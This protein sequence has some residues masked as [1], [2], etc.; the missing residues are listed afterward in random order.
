MAIC[1]ACE[2]TFSTKH[3]VR[4][5]R[6]TCASV[7]A[8]WELVCNPQ[9]LDQRTVSSKRA[10]L[11]DELNKEKELTE[12]N[13]DAEWEDVPA[14]YEDADVMSPP[15]PI[16]Q[17]PPNI[18][19]P[20][21]T[22]SG[23]VC[24]YPKKNVDFLPN[25]S[26]RIPHM[27]APVPRI[28][29]APKRVAPR[30]PTPEPAAPSFEPTVVVTL[31][32]EFG[33]YRE[34]P[35]F[36]EREIDDFEELD[37]L[38]NAPGLATSLPKESGSRLAKAMGIS[39]DAALAS[40]RFA[41]FLNAT[42]FCLM[43][44]F[45]GNSNL[46]SVQE[47]D[48]LVKN[49][50]LAEDFRVEHLKDFSAQRELARMDE[51]TSSES[52]SSSHSQTEFQRDQGWIN[53]TVKISLPCE[54]HQHASEDAAPVLEVPNVYHRS[55]VGTI[56]A[57][58]QDES[59]E[60]WH[61]TPHRLFWK[62]SPSSSPERIVTKIYN[63]DAFYNE[64]INLR[65]QQNQQVHLG[66]AHEIAIVALMLWSDSTQL[67]NFGNASLWPLYLLFGNQSKYVRAHP[68]SFS[69]HHIAYLP[70]LPKMLQDIYM[71]AYNGLTATA[72]TI[73]HLKRE[74]MH[75]IWLILLDEEFME[76]YEH[77]IIIK[78][79][80]GITR[81][82]FPRFFTYSADYPEKVLLATIRYLA[83]CVCP[84][85]LIQ[86]RWVSGLGTHVD[87]QRRSHIRLDTQQRRD[88]IEITRK[89]IYVH[90]RGVKSTRVEDILQDTSAVPTR[91][92]FS[93]RLSK[94]GFNYHSMFVPD[95]LHEFE[96]GVWKSFFTH[97]MRILVA[98]GGNCIQRLNWRYCKVATFGRNT[99][100]RFHRNASDMT[101]LAA[102][103]FEDL[104]QCSIPVFEG[105]LP[106]AHDKVLQDILFTLCEWH[107]LA[108]LRMHTDS[109][110]TGLEATTRRLGKELRSFVSKICPQYS[111]KELPKETAARARRA[112]NNAKKGKPAATGSLD[113]KTSKMLNL[114]TYKLHSLGDYVKTIWLFGPTEGYSTQRGKL[115]HRRVKRFFVRTNK[116]CKFEHQI[117]RHEHREHLLR[118]IA[119]RVLKLE[120]KESRENLG[121]KEPQ[122]SA[123]SSKK[124]SRPSKK[125][126]YVKPPHIVA[127]FESE[128]LPPLS[129]SE[130][131]Q[132]STSK[133][134]KLYIYE[135]MN[136]YCDDAAV[137][138]DFVS[139]L[140]DHFLARVLERAQIN[141]LGDR[142]YMHKVLRVNYTT[143]DIR[144]EQDSINPRNHCNIMTLSRDSEADTDH[145]YS[146]ARVLGVFDAD[147]QYNG[148]KTQRLEFLW[149][150]WFEVDHRFRAGW[151]ARR[152]DRLKFIHSD[153]PDAFGF[154]DPSDVLR[155]SHIIPSF[156]SGM[157]DSLL[158][159]SIARRAYWED[160]DYPDHDWNFYYVNRFVDRDMFVRYLGYGIG[161]KSTNHYTQHMRPAYFGL[162]T[163]LDEELGIDEA[164]PDLPLTAEQEAE[165]EASEPEDDIES[166]EEDEEDANDNGFVGED[167]EEPWD[168]DDTEAVGFADF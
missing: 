18:F 154:L 116:G 99:I 118:S 140:E 6:I 74:L 142:I 113:A 156:N 146:Y 14:T 5:H 94:F 80:D 1:D 152:L 26:T 131:H 130:H 41:P 73:T 115:E 111:T 45:Y 54:Q 151:A 149:V 166:E 71:K 63:S 67:A 15:S 19:V 168:I 164:H 58:L 160:D 37:N 90:G 77:G 28:R 23:R 13:Q 125:I 153:S 49:V 78:C 89:W 138:E 35:T 25:S 79:A 33:M 17:A 24:K 2:Q 62:P 30:E 60:L 27:P 104:L 52:H 106:P 122:S 158:P 97:M 95:F 16:S 88:R 51:A 55:L 3:A 39:I 167:G 129:P 163:N 120:E 109:T 48:H 157:T 61:F 34:Y 148:G 133:R 165:M 102:R 100:R 134:Y 75:A 40:N 108:K 7:L 65:K 83:K 114:F 22:R 59:A 132:M 93:I 159:P 139:R 91:N 29:P 42:V 11:D 155:A 31:P 64:Y 162:Y 38:C 96:L 92:A 10:R 127:T 21:P 112:A 150:R 8:D 20:P 12:P 72:A 76:A 47:L 53:S 136:N 126:S 103:D 66:D 141:I 147:V 105:L 36:P 81:R 69:A 68:S 70:T 119:A 110:L 145:P 143:Y 84:R 137:T 43:H 128:S 57:A 135:F 44:W 32:N 46:K 161:H 117:S 50:L 56:K 144:R 121:A 98:A 86:K 107:A 85:C 87:G 4:I 9:D 101:K 123:R 82:V 124:H